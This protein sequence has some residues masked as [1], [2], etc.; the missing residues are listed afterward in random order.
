MITLRDHETERY[1]VANFCVQELEIGFGFADKT[2]EDYVPKLVIYVI[3]AVANIIY[4]ISCILVRR[5]LIASIGI[6]CGRS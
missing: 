1:K 3:I 5:H 4:Y 6:H 2:Q